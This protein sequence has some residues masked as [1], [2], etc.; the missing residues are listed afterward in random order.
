MKEDEKLSK[1]IFRAVHDFNQNLSA[2]ERLEESIDTALFGESGKLDSLGLV[3]LIVLIEQEIE[4]E[5]GV[6]ITIADERAISRKKS[7]FKT[8]RRL[9][10][11]ISLLLEEQER[12]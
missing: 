8:I 4:D 12:G 3:N 6:S 1:A 7:P 11:Y 10:D 2:E 5:Y 9:A